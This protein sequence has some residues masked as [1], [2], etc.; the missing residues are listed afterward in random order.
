MEYKGIKFPNLG[1]TSCN[2]IVLKGETYIVYK[3]VVDRM[4]LCF[5]KLLTSG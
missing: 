4:G 1:N 5:S 2:I 3:Y